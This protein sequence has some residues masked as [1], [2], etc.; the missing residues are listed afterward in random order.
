LD[1]EETAGELVGTE[2]ETGGTVDVE[3]EPACV[4]TKMVVVLLSPDR[5]VLNVFCMTE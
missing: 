3:A 1:A 4:G 2:A 5:D